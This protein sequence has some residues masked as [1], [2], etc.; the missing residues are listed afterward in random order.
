[1][2]IGSSGH[3]QGVGYGRQSGIEKNEDGAQDMMD[4]SR[5][6]YQSKPQKFTQITKI[7]K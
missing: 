1:M 5:L 4:A 6:H 2:N 7:K 3:R